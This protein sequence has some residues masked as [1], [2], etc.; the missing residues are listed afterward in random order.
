MTA[1]HKQPRLSKRPAA[2][3]AELVHI[4]FY[5]LRD[6]NLNVHNQLDSL[7]FSGNRFSFMMTSDE[8]GF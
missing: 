6:L 1:E 4:S 3:L 7:A 2:S 5:A 8:N